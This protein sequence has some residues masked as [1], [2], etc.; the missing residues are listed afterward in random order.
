ML[1][2]C[3]WLLWFHMNRSNK[4]VTLKFLSKEL[5]LHV[6]T[7]SRILN[8]SMDDAS[9]AAAPE[10]IEKVKKL[11]ADLNYRPNTLAKSLQSQKTNVIGVLVPKLSDLV[12]ANIYEGIDAAATQNN[13]FTFVSNTNDLPINQ[14]KLGE[15]ALSRKVDGLIIADAHTGTE[16]SHQFFNELIARDIPF[17]L[18]SRSLENFTSVTCDDYLGGSL[19]A[20]HLIAEGHRRIAIIS[21]E[22]F[23]STGLLRTKGFKDYSASKNIIIPDDYI[24]NCGFDVDSGYQAGLEILS[25]NELP[26]A[27]FTVND[28]IAIGVMGAIKDKGYIPGK[29][30]AV[31]GFNNISL[32]AQ[33]PIPLTTIASPMSEMGFTAMELLLKKINKEQVDSIKLVPK[34]I[35]RNSTLDYLVE[36]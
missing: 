1:K 3:F 11:A 18:V 25:K 10:T 28:F 27:I 20:E 22:A 35:K 8:G 23:A 21:G 2:C 32:T 29:D 7:V 4:N 30:I 5:G 13:Y 19:A 24:I 14:K 9:S 12:L 33:L 15:M 34:L 6:S 36:R 16:N 26:T 17:V 31:V